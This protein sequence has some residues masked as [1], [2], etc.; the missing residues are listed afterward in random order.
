MAA[1][2]LSGR[3]LTVKDVEDGVQ[4]IF[5]DRMKYMDYD[6]S[7]DFDS[8]S[9]NSITLFD[10][11][12]PVGA[13][14]HDPF[15]IY[16]GTKSLVANINE[17]GYVRDEDAV[18]AF[19]HTYHECFHAW[20]LGVGY[21]R[22]PDA[23]MPA[24]KHMARDRALSVC[25]RSYGPCT[26]IL[27]AEEINAD[28]AAVRGVQSFFKQMSKCDSRYA[29]VDLDGIM[30]DTAIKRHGRSWNRVLSCRT[31]D[32]VVLAYTDMAANAPYRKR[33]DIDYLST[34]CGN[35]RRMQK[36]L[37]RTDFVLSVSNVASGIEQTDMLCRY[38]G[39]L[40]PDCFRSMLCIASEYRRANIK[41]FGELTIQKLLNVKPLYND[42]LQHLPNDGSPDF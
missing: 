42:A 32:D 6:V 16:I 23:A 9:D 41:N 13:M 40:Y 14:F 21:M 38:A 28:L 20:A 19:M 36:L 11:A 27:D 5:A 39:A 2:D 31:M 1:C 33:F 15:E 8:D 30:S 37:Q 17:S 26:Y 29:V 10:S 3:N 25:F 7:L 24:I 22:A 18:R 35:D 4:L 12:H 34:H